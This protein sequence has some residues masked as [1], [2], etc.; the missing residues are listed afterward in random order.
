MQFRSFGGRN[1]KGLV[2]SIVAAAAALTGCAEPGYVGY[3]AT[4]Y[5]AA[6]YGY[7]GYSSY[8]YPGW[9]GYQSP[10]YVYG[11][12][13]AP[14]YIDGRTARR[15]GGDR[16]HDGIPDRADRDRDGDGVPNRL[17]AR[18]NNPRRQ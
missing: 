4:G 15:G 5:G 9:S 11:G 6:G 13:S 18:P 16:D 10:G 3:G 17:D 12:V 14:V 1:M 2:F 8:G 7:P